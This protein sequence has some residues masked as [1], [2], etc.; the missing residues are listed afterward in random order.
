[1]LF[2]KKRELLK[3]FHE[4]ARKESKSLNAKIDENNM[5]NFI[6]FL[7]GKGL[8]N[9]EQK[10]KRKLILWNYFR[11]PN[12]LNSD[13]ELSKMPRENIISIVQDQTNYGYIIYWWEY[14]W[15]ENEKIEQVGEILDSDKETP[16]CV[17]H[18][19]T[20]FADCTCPRCKKVVG[21]REKWGD[22]NVRI[23]YQYCPYCGQ[24]LKGEDE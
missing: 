8:I 15:R 4:W 22:S 12:D 20:I 23:M 10:H 7:E 13:E 24:H 1:M 21:K 6:T 2:S 9:Y 5:C 17:T 3:E 18:E 11:D 16:Q 14:D 19:S